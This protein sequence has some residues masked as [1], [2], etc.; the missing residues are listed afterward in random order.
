MKN[1]LWW[2]GIG[3]YVVAVFLV[4]ALLTK[5]TECASNYLPCLEPNGLG[6]FLA[7]VFAP[8]AFLW[9]ARAVHMQS[10]QLEM[11]KQELMLTREEMKLA[12]EVAEDTQKEIKIQA[13]AMTLQK[14]I[15]QSQLDDERKDRTDKEV[16]AL[17]CNLFELLKTCRNVV[18]ASWK[19]KDSR[20]PPWED[21]GDSLHWLLFGYFKSDGAIMS[22]LFFKIAYSKLNKS[23]ILDVDFILYDTIVN[24]GTFSLL[25]DLIR[26]LQIVVDL[27]VGSGAAMKEYIIA[28]RL[29]EMLIDLKEAEKNL[30]DLKE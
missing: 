20:N 21:E 24:D 1:Y 18:A 22:P 5:E 8:L 3:I 9:L 14:D 30:L 19:K 2:I 29:T 7:G 28:S 26:N 11:Q 25:S 6:D 10:A 15:L 12:R 13:E 23:H 16:E 17:L 4:A 27:S